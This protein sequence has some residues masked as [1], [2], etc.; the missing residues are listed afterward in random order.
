MFSGWTFVVCLISH[1]YII[2]AS[3]DEKETKYFVNKD[4][5]DETRGKDKL[6]RLKFFNGKRKF[7][8]IIVPF[9]HLDYDQFKYII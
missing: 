1:G 4:I 5:Y 8:L 2:N 9:I 6:Q 7:K 3:F